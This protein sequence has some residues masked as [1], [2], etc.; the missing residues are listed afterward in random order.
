MLYIY[1]QAYTY[2][3]APC[4]GLYVVLDVSKVAL[5][6]EDGGFIVFTKTIQELTPSGVW[7]RKSLN[8]YILLKRRKAGGS[9]PVYLGHSVVYNSLQGREL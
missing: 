7:K 8:C 1:I 6:F 3:N 4:V 9:Y 2:E 5:D